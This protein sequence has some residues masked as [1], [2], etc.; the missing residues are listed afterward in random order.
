[1]AAF[2]VP[3]I[4]TVPA[5]ALLSAVRLSSAA[6]CGFIAFWFLCAPTSAFA[7][8]DPFGYL[9][10]ANDPRTRQFFREQ[11]AAAR[12]KLDAIPGRAHLLARIRQ[13]SSAS[14]V[15][16]SVAV[17]PT[18]VFYLKHEPGR[19]QPAL[20]MREGL[21]GAER[22]LL[23]PARFDR[24]GARAAID[25]Y[26]PSPDGRHVAY[27]VST[28]GSEESVL[29][30]L[31]T[32]PRRDLAVEI[33]R[34]RFNH[35][36]AWHPDGRS[37]YYARIPP[38]NAAGRRYAN[39]RIYRHVLGRPAQQDEIVFAAGAGGARDVPE[40]ARPSLHLPVES[41]YA[42]A[43][44]R[45]G[46][47]REIAVHVTE[48]RLLATGRPA[49]RKLAG[50][51][52]EVLAIEGWRDDLYVL[53]K[54]GAPRHRVLRVRG[55]SPDLGSAQV[56]VPQGDIV[57]RSFA[58]AR[59]ALY[60]RTMLGGVDRLERVPLGLLG[61]KAPEFVRIPFDNGITQIAADPRVAGAVLLLQGWI[62]PPMVVQVE[63]R[64]GNIRNT[65][66]H[67][68]VQVDFSAIDEVRLYAPAHDGTR[69]PV[70]L[71]YRKSTRLTGDNPTLLVGYGAYGEPFSPR[72]DPARLAWLERGGVY[73]IAHVRG[74]GEYGESWHEAGRRSAKPNTIRDFVAVAEF[75]VSYGFARPGRLAI[76]G[77][78]AGGIAAGGALVRR[79]TL[80]AA[81]VARS[82]LTDLVGYEKMAAGPENVPEFGSI[83]NPTDAEL[84]RGISAYHQ[85]APG[86]TY[87][88]VLLTAGLNDKRVDPWQPGKMAARLQASSTSG[89][90]VL[91]RVDPEAGHGAGTP[92]ANRD[93]ELADIFAFLLWQLGDPQFQASPTV[94]TAGPTGDATMTTGAQ[95]PDPTPAPRSDR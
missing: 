34:A 86:V 48:Q 76:A 75:L 7:N 26:V 80:F 43:I 13:L 38:T 67:P 85:V 95:A 30:V 39:V 36:L 66:V 87:P 69:I 18:R 12:A 42:Y 16:S 93:E 72:F 4:S 70:T 3:R 78:G 40:Q 32:D 24:D 9:E 60:L 8:D 65:R 54:R 15:V 45:D 94:G 6:I 83:A 41:R 29:R 46:V 17:T 33:D 79:P 5:L 14:A 27:G 81:V 53:S 64:T 25:W 74:G 50:Y 20:F 23:D 49:W 21:A 11:G 35:E 89:K 47:R 57:V 88:A 63:A 73:A 58:L 82:T 84:L 22:E 44:V 1:M 77:T 10:D 61:A 90:P 59:D 37:F 62:D 52:D 55:N 92:R 91:L 19:M 28:G 56:V 71:L 51:D 31:A 68:P 2:E